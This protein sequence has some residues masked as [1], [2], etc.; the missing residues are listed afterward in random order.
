MEPSAAMMLKS[1]GPRL[2]YKFQRLREQLRQ[3]ILTGQLVGQLPGERELARRFNA[4]A[5]TIN[6]ALADLAV[7]G[8]VKRY[9]GKGTFVALGS[10][11]SPATLAA[12]RSVHLIAPV[13][14]DTPLVAAVRRTL[15]A[16]GHTLQ[17]REAM[18]GSDGSVDVGP[19]FF[20]VESAMNAVL[21]EI[22]RPLRQ[23]GFGQPCDR[24]ILTLARRQVATILLGG[25][26]EAAR[27]HSIVPDFA[28]A[29]F[30]L[31][32]YLYDLGNRSVVAISTNVDTSEI[33]AA[34]RGY[35]TSCRRRGAPE[36][37]LAPESIAS[38]QRGRGEGIGYL[39][40]GGAALEAAVAAGLDRKRLVAVLDAD[41]PAARQ[42]HVT[43]Y[44]F[45]LGR[46]ADW[47]AR[48][49]EE[50]R[51]A[52]PPMQ[53]LVPGLLELRDGGQSPARGRPVG[54]GEAV[55]A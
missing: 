51:P 11:D 19:S 18:I 22:P 38:P 14:G 20:R 43:A 34:L 7:E 30:C 2:S 23:P 17:R 36:A 3:T 40:V 27:T 9:I 33:G 6:K 46:M 16:H 55:I 8:L 48:F 44:E 26:I 45:D 29:A 42:H 31:G 37:I 47:A 25:Q 5:K 12:Q 28:Q 13:A 35:R 10:S 39:C 21:F 4:N 15:T 24:L 54:P 41:D 53:V 1:P 50:I 49:V 32:E 52:T